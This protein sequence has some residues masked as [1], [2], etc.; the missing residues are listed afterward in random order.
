MLP[1]IIVFI[2]LIQK[3]L[4]M[5]KSKKLMKVETCMQMEASIRCDLD[6]SGFYYIDYGRRFRSKMLLI[7]HN[8]F[9]LCRLTGNYSSQ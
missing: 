1:K 4:L 2:T 3:R 5:E 8:M 6:C 9:L 7:F